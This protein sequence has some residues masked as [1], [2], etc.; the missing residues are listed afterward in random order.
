MA[1]AGGRGSLQGLEEGGGVG[2]MYVCVCREGGAGRSVG[3]RGEVDG[4]GGGFQ[5]RLMRWSGSVDRFLTHCT[6]CGALL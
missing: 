1:P 5:F 2:C 3:G 4:G 6:V